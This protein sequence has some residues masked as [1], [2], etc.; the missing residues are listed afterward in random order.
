MANDKTANFKLGVA[1]G[2]AVPSK[3][4]GQAMLEQATKKPANA[5]F[6]APA[7]PQSKVTDSRVATPQGRADQ[8]KQINAE[9][10][11]N[12]SPNAGD[13]SEVGMTADSK[14]PFFP[15]PAKPT[16]TPM[17]TS[18]MDTLKQHGGKIKSLLGNL[19]AKIQPKAQSNMSMPGV[20]TKLKKSEDIFAMVDLLKSTMEKLG[21]P[22]LTEKARADAAGWTPSESDKAVVEKNRPKPK[23]S[24]PSSIDINLKPKKESA[25]KQDVA[26]PKAPP[27]AEAKSTPAPAAQAAPDK[28]PSGK[29]AVAHKAIKSM[30]SH[31]KLKQAIKGKVAADVAP[32]VVPVEAKHAAPKM[33]PVQP[34]AKTAAIPAARRTPAEIHQQ[35]E[36]NKKAKQDAIWSEPLSYEERHKNTEVARGKTPPAKA[37]QDAEDEEFDSI[38]DDAKSKAVKSGKRFYADGRHEEHMDGKAAPPKAAPPKAAPPKAAPP[39]AAPPKAAP[40]KAA[41]PKAPVKAKPQSAPTKASLP[42][43]SSWAKKALGPQSSKPSSQPAKPVPAQSFPDPMTPDEVDPKPF[44]HAHPQHKSLKPSHFRQKFQPMSPESSKL[45]LQQMLQ[46]HMAAGDNSEEVTPENPKKAVSP[47]QN[48]SKPG[49]VAASG[50]K[51][52]KTPGSA[53]APAGK[54]GQSFEERTAAEGNDKLIQ[55]K[56]QPKVSIQKPDALE[57]A[58]PDAQSHAAPVEPRMKIGDIGVKKPFKPQEAHSHLLSFLRNLVNP[59]TPDPTVRQSQQFMG[60]S[61]INKAGTPIPSRVNFPGSGGGSGTGPHHSNQPPPPPAP[62]LAKEETTSEKSAEVSKT[63]AEVNKNMGAGAPTMPT[64]S[65]SGGSASMIKEETET[66]AKESVGATSLKIKESAKDKSAKEKAKLMSDPE[67]YPGHARKTVLSLLGNKKK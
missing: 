8:L 15:T 42:G 6:T 35:G 51:S 65:G 11:K 58:G 52:G 53:S 39:K 37:K 33:A 61:E 10:Q 45:K 59:G 22:G 14:K 2:G 44:E 43:L 34:D 27:Q 18:M 66:T 57:M 4:N 60:K 38:R 5:R 32:A 17:K 55:P 20:N 64:P 67:N 62:N 47:E 21:K 13:Q 31:G 49:A 23:T 46:S 41:P 16:K 40:P 50:T 24:A 3:P 54:S 30:H 12:M 25:P 19:G 29:M 63:K 28:K 56:A 26:P 36:K 9:A 7:T 48:Q 1:A